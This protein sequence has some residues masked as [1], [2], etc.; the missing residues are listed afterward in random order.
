M[1]EVINNKFSELLTDT[2]SSPYGLDRYK[3]K[4]R[5][6][7]GTVQYVHSHSDVIDRRQ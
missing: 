5:G 6:T 3:K 7:P 1:G 4:A 2:A